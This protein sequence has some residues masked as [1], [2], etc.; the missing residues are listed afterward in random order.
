MIMF[1]TVPPDDYQAI[2]LVDL[3][4]RFNWTYVS[5]VASEGSYGESGIEVFHREAANRNICI[6]TAERVPSTADDRVF[7]AIITSLKRKAHARAVI[8]FTRA[9]DAR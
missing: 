2:T 9:D 6:A 3:V 5:T 1:S 7:E 8:L 4:E